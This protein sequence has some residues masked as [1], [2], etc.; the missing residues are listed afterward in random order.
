[1]DANLAAVTAFARIEHVHTELG[2]IAEQLPPGVSLTAAEGRVL[3]LLTTHASLQDIA[4]QLFVARNTVKTHA[5]SVYR[6][7]G[8]SSRGEAVQRAREAHL[9]H[10]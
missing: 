9:L 7:L 10:C 6:K 5:L 8:V 2:R 4:A 3:E 1:M